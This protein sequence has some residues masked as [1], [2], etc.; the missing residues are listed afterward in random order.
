M[1]RTPTRYVASFSTAQLTGPD[2]AADCVFGEAGLIAAA[3]KREGDRASPVGIWPVRRALFRA[4]R[5][6]PPSTALKL[7]PITPEDGWCD[8]PNDIAYNRAVRLPYRGRHERLARDDGLYDLVVILGH[9]DDPPVIGLGSAIFLHC[10][11]PDGKATLGCLALERL[12]LVDLVGR[13]RPGDEVE[14]AP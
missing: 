3:D 8:D 11:N 10:R 6:E 14:I 13:L 9:N 2:V 12:T 4:D 7:D 1:P 5:I